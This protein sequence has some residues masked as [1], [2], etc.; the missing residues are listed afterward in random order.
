MRIRNFSLLLVV[1]SVML[2]AAC[3]KDGTIWT[4]QKMAGS[5]TVQVVCNLNPQDSIIGEPA[6]KPDN[7]YFSSEPASLTL[8]DDGNSVTVQFSRAEL[9]FL[10]ISLRQMTKT[11]KV[12]YLDLVE[13]PLRLKFPSRS[14]EF[15]AVATLTSSRTVPHPK[16]GPYS[17]ELQMR[18]GSM[19]I[20]LNMEILFTPKPGVKREKQ[21]YSGKLFVDINPKS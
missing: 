5:H 12:A 17:A 16:S 7:T 3:K 18:S 19:S 21:R 14:D 8:E 10:V 1:A 13:N 2:L 20:K 11:G 9:R 4:L 6:Y 15:D